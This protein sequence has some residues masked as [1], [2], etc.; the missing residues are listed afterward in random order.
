MISR[1]VG[2]LVLALGAGCAGSRAASVATL[3]VPEAAPGEDVLAERVDAYGEVLATQGFESTPFKA[4][5]FLPPLAR[6]TYPVSIAAGHCALFV[7]IA[8]PTVDDLDAAVYSAGG[9]ALVEDDGSDARPVL[10]LCAGPEPLDVYYSVHAYQ[11]AGAFVA[12]I[13]QRP[14]LAEDELVTLADGGPSP[15]T[16]QSRQLRKRGFEDAAAPVDLA[17]EPASPVRMAMRVA[18]GQC[19]TLVAEGRDGLENV[20][21]R[22]L[23]AGGRELAFGV[24]DGELAALQYCAEESSDYGVELVADRGQG[25]ARVV[26][27]HAPQSVI[28]GARALWL[29]EPSPSERARAGAVVKTR[30]AWRNA[31]LKERARLSTYEKL[32]LAQGQTQ[33]VAVAPGSTRCERFQVELH[34]GLTRVKLRVE[35]LDGALLGEA[36]AVRQGASVQLCNRV[37]KARVVVIGEAGF[38]SLTL[39]GAALQNP[40]N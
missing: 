13:F 22:L 7:A 26:R 6:D 14:A 21:M 5:G 3:P 36:Q 38:G 8:S 23:D 18:A 12:R 32:T 11:G 9:S 1:A 19:Y 35:A 39:V 29:G 4:R 17:L 33:E 24:G 10:T 2:A 37:A 27:F 30:E 40:E 31:L 20:S 25:T 34:D 16:E 28:G 15:L